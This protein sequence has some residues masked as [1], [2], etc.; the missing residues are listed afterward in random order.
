MSAPGPH[1]KL[2]I[3]GSG[4]IKG[5]GSA[6]WVEGRFERRSADSPTADPSGGHF[7]GCDAVPG[8]YDELRRQGVALDLHLFDRKRS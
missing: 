1:G 5:R 6:S 8:F 2:R 7:T 3:P 4:A